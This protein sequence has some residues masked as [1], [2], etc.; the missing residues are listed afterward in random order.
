MPSWSRSPDRR[1]RPGRSSLGESMN[2]Q[3]ISDDV[4]RADVEAEIAR[5][6]GARHPNKVVLSPAQME[7]LI[8]MRSAGLIWR[9]ISAFFKARGLCMSEKTL[10]RIWLE[11]GGNAPKA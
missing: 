3:P 8:A 9:D 4:L 1:A 5:L 2:L 10:R 7:G 6:G 11:D